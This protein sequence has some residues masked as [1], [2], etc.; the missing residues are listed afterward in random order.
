ML[1]VNSCF[2]SP[3]CCNWLVAAVRS[4]ASWR[5]GNAGDW[6]SFVARLLCAEDEGWAAKHAEDTTASDSLLLSVS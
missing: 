1:Y 6:V 2:A 4:G 3:Y 5:A